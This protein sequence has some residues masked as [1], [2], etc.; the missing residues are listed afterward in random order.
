MRSSLLSIVAALPLGASCAPA[1][2]P[3]SA[4]PVPAP[5]VEAGAPPAGRERFAPPEAAHA[6][7]WM[8]LAS[9][10]VPE[11]RRRYPDYD[12]RGVLI[13]ILDTGV[14]PGVAGLAALPTGAPKVLDVRD[15]SGEGR[16]ALAEVRLVGDRVLVGALTLAGA[17]RLRG[18]HAGGPI[19]GGILDEARLGE[20]PAA[21]LN[22]N[23]RVGDSLAVVVIRASDGWV[24]FADTDGN[25]SLANERPVRDYLVGRQTFG[26][27]TGRR[28]APTQVAVNLADRGPG[29]PPELD[30]VFDT[31]GHGTHVAGIA[32]GQALYG[33]RG[34]DGVAPG[35]ELLAIKFSNNARGGITV[36]GSMVRAMD[37]A[38]RFATA[39]QRP[40]VINMSF[41]VGNERVGAARIDHLVDSIL[42]AHPEVVLTASAGNDGPGLS[43]IGFPASARRVINVGAS[44]PA[45]FMPPR[46]DGRDREDLVAFF[47]ARGAELAVPDLVVP[48]VAYSTVPPFD[49]GDEVKNGTSMAAPHAAGLVARL[50]SGLVAEGRRTDAA[51]IRRVLMAS[52]RP[53]AGATW[54]DQGAG[55]PELLRA[56]ELLRH[57][58]GPAVTVQ[59]ATHGVSAAHHSGGVRDTVQDFHL[60]R[61]PAGNPP[62]FYRLQSTVPWI[63]APATVTLTDTATVRV[64]LDPRQVAA[65]GFHLGV[66]EGWG[67]DS[68]LGPAFRLV[69]TVTVPRAGRPAADTVSLT[70]EPGRLQRLFFAVDSGRPFNLFVTEPRGAPLL[71]FLHEPGGMPWRDGHAQVVGDADTTTAFHATGRDVGGGVYELVLVTGPAEFAAPTVIM[72]RARGGATVV[73]RGD[74][75]VPGPA[76][77]NTERAMVSAHLAGLGRE[78]AVVSHGSDDLHIPFEVPEW[79]QLVVVET[80]MDRAQWPRFTDFGVTLLDERGF[81]LAAKPLNYHLGRLEYD[82]A[83]GGHGRMA[84][85]LSPGFAEPTGEEWH[86][87]VTIRLQTLEP[88]EVA[89]PAPLEEGRD[90]VWPLP[91]DRWVSPEG[92]GPL[93][94]IRVFSG[95]GG[96]WLDQ[97]LLPPEP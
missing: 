60:R 23:G 44:H 65:P 22:G 76:P 82:P 10:R 20:P 47:S 69:Q 84:L 91:L 80:G 27:R 26:W 31:S 12:G 75:V 45:A 57:D 39:R 87:R 64:R 49:T 29:E 40:L 78:F 56:W 77:S 18:I 14:D 13:A 1:P 32:A 79:V 3:P 11:F 54:L 36:T 96:P 25:G 50:L 6:L 24:L 81:Q 88:L 43:T 85:V 94:L 68:A 58:A 72:D 86:A 34:F 28:P 95:R 35:A 42:A 90:V 9:T 53:L 92:F 67:A 2:A 30:L 83:G 5:P 19:Y 48:G 46:P 59:A 38:I 17:G 66:V 21:D 70:L 41:G 33:V 93:V 97:V 4:A 16:V 73:R 89:E 15:F 51:T 71:A 55:Q 63:Q 62:S 7:G 52:A 61:E 74:A 37:Y 8:P